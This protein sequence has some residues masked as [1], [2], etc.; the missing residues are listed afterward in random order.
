[1]KITKIEIKDFR[2]IES[3]ALDLLGPGKKPLDMVVL[4]GPN[5]CGKTSILEACLRAFRRDDLLGSGRKPKEDIL[6][7]ANDFHVALT[8]DVNGREEQVS[9]TSNSHDFIYE[10]RWQNPQTGKPEDFSTVSYYSSWRYP[11]LVG[12]IS[13]TAGKRGKRPSDTEDNRLWRL[14]QYLVN[15]TARKGFESSKGSGVVWETPEDAFARL[16]RVWRMFYPDR[17]EQFVAKP[18]SEDIEAGFDVILERADG[19]QVSMDVLS[20]GEIEVLCLLGLIV[21]KEEHPDILF[22]DEP[23]LHLHP[24]WHRKMLPALK[25]VMPGSQIIAATHSPQVLG[26]IPA[27][28]VRLLRRTKS[29][30]SAVTPE[31]SYG[32]DADRI[33]EDLL[34]VPEREPEIEG[35][36]HDLF[37]LVDRNDLPKARSRLADLR[38]IIPGDPELAKADVLIRRKEAL[39][40]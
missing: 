12:S 2:G 27:D 39:G 10:K 32:L 31:S 19:K 18:A 17:H 29:G 4:A 6:R 1:M 5:G 15:L 30:L 16:N 22:L 20:A 38:A 37:N 7:G 40:K 33:L 28:S 3:L 23:E 25:E 35:K 21:A 8:L 24:A 14:K 36:L 13:V 34:E 26:G 9:R 11:K